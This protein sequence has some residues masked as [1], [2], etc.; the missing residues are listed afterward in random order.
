MGHAIDAG[1]GIVVVVSAEDDGYSVLDEERLQVILDGG[2]VA[3]AAAG[4]PAGLVQ[5]DQFPGLG[6]SRQIGLEPVVLSR[7]GRVRSVLVEHGDVHGAI[8]EGPV[9]AA[10]LEGLG[11]VAFPK[12]GA[13][14]MVAAHAD[15]GEVGILFAYIRIAGSEPLAGPGAFAIAADPVTDVEVEGLEGGIGREGCVD[16]S[17]QAVVGAAVGAGIAVGEE[18][19]GGGTG[20]RGGVEGAGGALGADEEPVVILGAWGE[21]A[22]IVT[23]EMV[24]GIGGADSNVAGGIAGVGAPLDLEGGVGRPLPGDPHLGVGAGEDQ[25]RPFRQCDHRTAG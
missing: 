20:G 25:G 7:A 24:G 8:I 2:V 22:D 13:A 16:L 11:P 12:R 18:L 5:D 4:R 21:A 6:G 3:M 1:A 14:F 9:Q 23:I 15:V 10:G 17:G 19:D